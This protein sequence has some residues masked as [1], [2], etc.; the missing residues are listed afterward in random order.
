MD[1]VKIKIGANEYDIKDAVVRAWMDGSGSGDSFEQQVKNIVKYGIADTTGKTPAELEQLEET[2][3]S[4]LFTELD[5]V[6]T[7]SL[8]S[9]LAATVDAN[10]VLTLVNQ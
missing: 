10:G 8:A 1:V 3:Q 6:F 4:N 5:P 9:K 2:Q 7:Q